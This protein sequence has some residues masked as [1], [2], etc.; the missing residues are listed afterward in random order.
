MES[1]TR[2]TFSRRQVDKSATL[3]P[4]EL[5][6]RWEV[7]CLVTCREEPCV[8]VHMN[9]HFKYGTEIKSSET[10]RHW[11]RENQR[12]SNSGFLKKIKIGMFR[13]QRRC[14]QLSY[15]FWFTS[16]VNKH[17]SPRRKSTVCGATHQ[18]SSVARDYWTPRSVCSSV[19][20]G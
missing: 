2:M 15:H 5:P 6:L 1:T 12:C 16:W 17:V 20:W 3:A 14:R 7:V 19:K 8:Q 13:A 10:H 18:S 9:I 11:D 4:L